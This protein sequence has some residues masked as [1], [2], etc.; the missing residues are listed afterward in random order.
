MGHNWKNII[1]FYNSCVVFHHLPGLYI[2]L[3]L[4][5]ALLIEV[6]KSMRTESIEQHNYNKIKLCFLLWF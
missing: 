6:L 5:M 3:G 4:N 1:A 2:C